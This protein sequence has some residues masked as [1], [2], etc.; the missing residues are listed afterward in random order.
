MTATV[1]TG[2][3]AD[4]AGRLSLALGALNRRIRPANAG[5]SVGLVSALA[6]VADADGLRP[7]DLARIEGVAAPS[8][9]RA[10][11]ELEA[12]GFVVRETDPQDGRAVL[13]RATAAGS[14]AL[15]D[16]R[17]ER[18]RRLLELIDVE[19]DVDLARLSDAVDVLEGLLSRE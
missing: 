12:R 15:R 13:V 18:A 9:T 11:A 1:S 19:G 17:K 6:T 3:R 4:I 2:T 16:A 7:S 8:A 10:V 14:K 5:M